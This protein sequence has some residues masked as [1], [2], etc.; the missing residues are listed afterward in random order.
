MKRVEISFESESTRN[1]LLYSFFRDFSL[2]R[3]F[4]TTRKSSFDG[5]SFYFYTNRLYKFSYEHHQTRNPISCVMWLLAMRERKEQS[6]SWERKL[7]ER[8]SGWKNKRKIK[9]AFHP[10][11]VKMLPN[12]ILARLISNFRKD[13]DCV[14]LCS[15]ERHY[16]A[17]NNIKVHY[18][19]HKFIC[20]S[21][22]S[23]WASNN[24]EGPGFSLHNISLP[25]MLYLT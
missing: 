22:F 5:F 9:G 7:Q 12:K 23:L 10:R 17:R 18:K 14:A 15:R 16:S 6:S 1:K 24:T 13:F 19:E 8:A 4:L 2:S 3:N 20:P 25:L 11:R 21:V